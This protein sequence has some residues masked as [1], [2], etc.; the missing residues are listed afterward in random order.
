MEH[1]SGII[2]LTDK[3]VVANGSNNYSSPKLDFN[4]D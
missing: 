4:T 3:I 2:E 1:K